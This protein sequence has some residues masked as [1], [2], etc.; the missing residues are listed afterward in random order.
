[1]MLRIVAV[2]QRRRR[3]GAIC[4]LVGC[5]AAVCMAVGT[6]VYFGN[7]IFAGLTDETIAM[8]RNASSYSMLLTAMLCLSAGGLLWM[9]RLLRRRLERRRGEGSE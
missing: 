7:G 2:E 6:L 8:F 4:A 5:V 3:I 9:D 1:M